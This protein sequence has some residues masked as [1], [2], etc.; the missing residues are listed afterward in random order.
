VLK[1]RTGEAPYIVA[2]D[3]SGLVTLVQLG[4]VEFHV[5]GSRVDK[6]ERPDRVVF[7]LDPD[8]GIPW[9]R[10]I[11]AAGRVRAVLGQ[12]DLTSCVKTTGGKGL[13]V[14]VPIPG[15]H[16]WDEV[17][18]FSRRVAGAIT[19]AEPQRYTATLSKARR[20]GRVLIDWL[21]NARGATWVCAWSPRARPGLSV[22]MPLR[23]EELPKLRAANTWSIA[24][25]PSRLARD[26]WRGMNAI[27]QRLPKAS[28]LQAG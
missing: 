15:R 4:V 11:E 14:E 28:A 25:A 1:E 13:H 18:S 8:P 7:D 3:T 6:P 5:W 10:V 16:T 17:K 24:D 23:W 19:A 20:H 9:A 12:L 27:D 22:A 2:S 21:R 26:P